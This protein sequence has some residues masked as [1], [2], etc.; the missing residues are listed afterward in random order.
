MLAIPRWHGCRP[1]DQVP[2]QF[3]CY[4]CDEDGEP[5]LREWLAE[6]RRGSPPRLR[7]PPRRGLPRCRRA[8]RLVCQLRG[9]LHPRACRE[10]A[11]S[12]RR[13]A[14]RLGP[15]R[16][17]APD[18]AR[19]RLPPRLRRAASRSRSVLPALV[20]DLSYESLEIQGGVEASRVL[21]GL[22]LG[23]DG[24]PSRGARAP[25]RG[26]QGL[27]PSRHV[28]NGEAARQAP[29]TR[30]QVASGTTGG[31]SAMNRDA[32]RSDRVRGCLLGGAVGDAMGAPLE[33]M[34]R[35]DERATLMP[36]HLI[37]PRSRSGTATSTAERPRPPGDSEA[38]RRY[39]CC[40]CM[41][42]LPRSR[43]RPW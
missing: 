30:C 13:P 18:R 24:D 37:A 34:K 19:T 9:G 7:P 23:A 38:R 17:P 10:R 12:R 27:L 8:A 22:V 2:A 6:R 26:A 5:Q 14:R 35:L 15:H 42:A 21:E 40:A 31:E 36:A 11:G 28:G 1:Y 16:G 25:A 43:A 41:S 29:R 33:F 20:P 39:A 32:T 4:V 3:V